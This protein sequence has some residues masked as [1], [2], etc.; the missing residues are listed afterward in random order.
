MSFGVGLRCRVAA[1]VVWEA[2]ALIQPLAWEFSY[3]M[4][5]ALKRQK[6]KK[7]KKQK[8]EYNIDLGVF[9]SFCLFFNFQFS[10]IFRD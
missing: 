5:A 4:G 1:A 10:R 8:W 2:T 9:I 6:K 3:A 7:K